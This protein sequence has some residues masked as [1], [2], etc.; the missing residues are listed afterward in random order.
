MCSELL[1]CVV[2]VSTEHAGIVGG[3]WLGA[4]S[5]VNDCT[6]S[7]YCTVVSNEG[8]DMK[9]LVVCRELVSSW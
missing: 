1:R 4:C 2:K 5:K 7:M 3:D 9:P 6:T 8:G